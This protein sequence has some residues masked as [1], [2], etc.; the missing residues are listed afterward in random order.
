MVTT[1]CPSDAYFGAKN[2]EEGLKKLKSHGFDCI[3][4]RDFFNP[5]GEVYQMDDK[6]LK[7]AENIGVKMWQ[8][9]AAWPLDDSTAKS[10]K[11]GDKVYVKSIKAANVLGCKYL[12]IHPAV[13]YGWGKEPSAQEVYDINYQRFYNLLPCAK[14]NGVTLCLENMPFGT[15][16]HSFSKV[17][18]VKTF[19]RNVNDPY[20]GVCF[21]TGHAFVTG[22]NCYDAIKTLGEDLMTLHVH[23]DAGRQDRHLFPFQGSVD[24]EGFIKGLR[25]IG[26]DGCISLETAVSG[27][28]PEP[29]REQMRIAL[30]GICRYFADRI[31]SK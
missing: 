27:K 12:V 14:D 8:M 5:D 7:A 2:Y 11:A 17:K 20:L 18:D 30:A 9:H 24:W 13:P 16:G 23:D 1:G 22:D 31:G 19:V 15:E 28:T 26:F 21:D 25:E 4:Y 6:K 29:M 10:R 3:D